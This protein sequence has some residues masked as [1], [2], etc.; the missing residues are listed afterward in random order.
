MAKIEK[1]EDI[2]AWRK[3]RKLV[4]AIYQL[5]DNGKF[6]KDFTLKDQIRKSGISVVSNI[7]EGFAR[8][9][10]KEFIQFLY[11]SHGSVAEIEA[12]LYVALDLNYIEK[13]KFKSLYNDCYD[14]SKMLMGLIKYLSTHQPI[15][16]ATHKQK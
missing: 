8:R 14:I 12:Q 7:A 2:E 15:N 9:T 11:F 3:A 4:S 16:P 1:F 5:S 13:D 10:N 6:K